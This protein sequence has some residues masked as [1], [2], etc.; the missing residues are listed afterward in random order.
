[1][2][3]SSPTSAMLVA[4][5]VPTADRTLSR[6]TAAKSST[7]RMPMI[8][9]PCGLNIWPV[10]RSIFTMMAELL[11]ESAAPRKKASVAVHPIRMPISYPR[12]TMKVIS[13]APIRTTRRPICRIRCH[14]N[15]RPMANRNSTR[16]R[17][18]RSLM[19]STLATGLGSPI[20]G[21]VYGPT[22]T[23]AMR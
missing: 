5:V 13:M 10:S 18:A 21:R 9:R 8:S 16:P 19:L 11:M 2:P 14:P 22:S 23:P 12:A 4:P 20:S 7:T 1:M 6:I 15:S 3:D 17:S